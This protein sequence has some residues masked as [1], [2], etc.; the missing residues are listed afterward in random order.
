MAIPATLRRW[1][2]ISKVQ[3]LIEDYANYRGEQNAYKVS[4]KIYELIL[5]DLAEKDHEIA[6]NIRDVWKHQQ[7]GA[8][9]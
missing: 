2:T 4:V 5:N 6:E 3:D 1:D 8:T 7:S 9:E